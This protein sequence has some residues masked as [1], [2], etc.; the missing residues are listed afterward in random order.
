M[1]RPFLA[2]LLG[3]LRG[4]AEDGMK[5]GACHLG[6]AIWGSALN[7]HPRASPFPLR[8]AESLHWRELRRAGPA[9]Q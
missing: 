3:E 1:S 7:W 9:C 6:G 8:Q 5:A 4:M 2:R